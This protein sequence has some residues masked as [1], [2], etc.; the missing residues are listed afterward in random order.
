VRT[1]KN[2]WATDETVLRIH[3]LPK[4]GQLALSKD[5]RPVTPGRPPPMSGLPDI[6]IYL[7]KSAMADL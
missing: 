6:G 4:L 3:I 7:R 2:S 1:Y 5:E